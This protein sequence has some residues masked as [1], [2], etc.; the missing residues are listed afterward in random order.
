M[1]TLLNALGGAIR[2][3]GVYVCEKPA[4]KFIVVLV[5]Q[6][7]SACTQPL[8]LSMP[9][10]LAALWFGDHERTIANTI[11]SICKFLVQS[12]HFRLR[13]EF[14]LIKFCFFELRQVD[15]ILFCEAGSIFYH[16]KCSF[17]LFEGL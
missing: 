10:K 8:V 14:H 13:T 1:G 6:T 5:G 7:L 2:I 11:A 17:Y 15:T 4:N 3:I 12:C 9:T 16:R